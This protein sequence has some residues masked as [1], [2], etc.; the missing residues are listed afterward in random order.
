MH[1][2]DHR[3]HRGKGDGA[4]HKTRFV[5]AMNFFWFE[6]GLFF[7]LNQKVPI[8]DIRHFILCA[9]CVLCGL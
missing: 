2:R 7:N 9:L 1:H 8:D 6:R 3:E 4:V 5:M